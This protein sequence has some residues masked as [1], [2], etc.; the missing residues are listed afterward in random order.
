MGTSASVGLARTLATA[1]L[2][3]W[4]YSHILDDALLIVSELVTN[5]IQ[6][7]PDEEIRFQV[8]RD[9][10]GLII[11]VWDRDPQYP[12]P[13]PRKVL[14][15]DDLDVSEEAFD[16]NGGRGLHIVRALSVRC[17]ATRDLGGGKWVWARMR[18]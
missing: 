16:D 7:T 15:L 4:D 13:K 2:R 18:P 9:A 11:A 8:S 3:N 6:W 12:R 10:D 17:G 5:A 14:T 1:R